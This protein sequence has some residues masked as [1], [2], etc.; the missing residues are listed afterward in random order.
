MRHI[1]AVKTCFFLS[2]PT[3]SGKSLTFEISPY[4][5]D[6]LD[7]GERDKIEAICLVIVPLKA[8]MKSQVE[9]LRARG[10]AA[11]FIGEDCSVEEFSQICQAKFN[12]LFGSPE[13]F[14]NSSR[15]IF[16]CLKKRVKAVFVDE[17]HC[18]EKWYVFMI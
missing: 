7:Y 2:A 18:I 10:I 15:K 12:I 8:L 14:L 5:F 6:Y 16:H 13:A 1:W 4:V 11:A 3:G 17:S 9:S